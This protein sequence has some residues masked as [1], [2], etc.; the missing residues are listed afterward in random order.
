[1]P[2]W[3]SSR[4][5]ASSSGSS[6]VSMPPSPVV[7]TLR[8]WNEKHAMSPC[9]LPIFCHSPFQ[10]ISLPSGARRVL[11]DRQAV[12]VRDGGATGRGRTACPI[13]CTT[14]MALVRGVIAASMRSGSMLWVSGSMSTN[15]GVAPQ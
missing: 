5:L 8:G 4:N 6:V 14:R 13:W 10:R 7:T 3:R 11:D 15:T 2:C 9:G 1:M 12:G